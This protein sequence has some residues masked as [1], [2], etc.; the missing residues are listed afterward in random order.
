M[1]GKLCKYLRMCGIDTLYSNEG[2][3]S[4]LYAKREGRIFITK[5]LRLKDKENVFFLESDILHVQLKKIINSFNL[6][7]Q[8][9][10]FSRCLCCNEMLIPVK[11]EEIKNNIPYYTYKNFDEF[12]QCPKCKRIYWKG[13]HYEKMEMDIKK[14]LGW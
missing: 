13:S 6:G 12:A 14:M 8:L 1:L 5:N 9:N 2:M 11:K 10:F 7:D 3:K 4:W